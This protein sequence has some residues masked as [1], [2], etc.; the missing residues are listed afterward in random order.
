MQRLL[1]GCTSLKT[2]KLPPN[3]GV[4]ADKAFNN[5]TNLINIDF[6]KC[7]KLTKIYLEAFFNCSALND[8]DLSKCTSLN[9]IGKQAF[10][11]CNNATITLP[12]ADIKIPENE[13]TFGA[14]AG[15]VKKVRIHED[16]TVLK[17]NVQDSCSGGEF[18][19]DRIE[20]YY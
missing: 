4:I 5:C 8:I 9:E 11:G 20:S 1:S 13:D 6:S 12:N 3:L 15:M 14:G 18:P 2:I 16:N 19:E 17:N 7:T 10:Y